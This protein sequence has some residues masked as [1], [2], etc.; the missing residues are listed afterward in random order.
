M[1]DGIGDNEKGKKVVVFDT[2]VWIKNPNVLNSYKGSDICLPSVVLEEMEDKKSEGGRFSFCARRA[3]KVIDS[4]IPEDDVSEEISLEGGGKLIFKMPP[5]KMLFNDRSNKDNWII[6]TAL[7]LKE[8][9]R[10]VIFVSYDKN[11]RL[12]ARSVGLKIKKPEE[13]K[14]DNFGLIGKIK[15]DLPDAGS[16][17]YFLDG[18][19]LYKIVGE[20]VSEVKKPDMKNL[21][22]RNNEQSCALDALFDPDIS[23]VALTGIAGTGKTI[24]SLATGI[25]LVTAETYIKV[26]V[27]RAVVPV[28]K[29]LG[30]LPGDLN[31]KLAPWVR[32]FSDNF[33]VL[34]EQYNKSKGK[35]DLFSY[36]ALVSAGLLEFQT[37]EHS[38]GITLPG[39]FFIIDEVQN[40]TPKEVKTLVSRAGEGA[41]VILIG[42]IEQGDVEHLDEEYNGLS[43]LID[44][45]RN[46]PNF[47]HLKLLKSERSKV[48]AQ[49]AR[50]L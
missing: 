20:K 5:S 14:K 21:F 50:L 31:E 39:V 16:V 28:G 2:N 38:R 26:V 4:L 18:K 11:A 32:P 27:S 17:R 29:T 6:A 15:E 12:K 41:K 1:G 24:L 34:S 42:D 7:A 45:F 22:S 36:D 13:A 19:K 49:A 44:R 47:C 10:D 46:E 40:M 23:V 35:K 8:E 37:L 25:K 48:A 9:G 43:H 33:Q 3:V 30:L